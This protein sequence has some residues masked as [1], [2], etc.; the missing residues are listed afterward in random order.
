MILLISLFI[1]LFSAVYESERIDELSDLGSTLGASKSQI[2]KK[3][4]TNCLRKTAV[5]LILFI[6]FVMGNYEVP[7]LLGGQNPQLIS[8]AIVQNNTIQLVRYS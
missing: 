1:I 5:S 8:V 2:M 6:L 3:C 4:N 7:L